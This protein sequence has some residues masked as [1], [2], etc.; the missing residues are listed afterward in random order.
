[1][2]LHDN[3]MNQTNDCSSVIQAV[4][5]CVYRYRDGQIELLLIRKKHGYWTLPKGKNEPGETDAMAVLREVHEET[6]ITGCLGAQV[7]QVAYTISKKNKPV[8]K[9]VTYYLIYAQGGELVPS[10]KERIEKLRWFTLQAALK[11]IGRGRVRKVAQ[12]AG[13]LLRAQERSETMDD[14]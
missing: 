10:K 6:G 12:H 4:G 5:G 13:A 11:R 2:P 9:V 14:G 3:T 7:R 8:P 1:M